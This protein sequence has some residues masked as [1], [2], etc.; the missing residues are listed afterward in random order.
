[1]SVLDCKKAAKSMRE[2][3]YVVVTGNGT[4]LPHGCIW[5][6]VNRE[7][8]YVYWNT[9]GSAI[10]QDPNLRLICED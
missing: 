10:S 2:V 8:A 7:E 3:S 4:L 1:M 5:D 6:K 9:L